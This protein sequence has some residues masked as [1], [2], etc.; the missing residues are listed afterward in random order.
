VCD[1]LCLCHFLQVKGFSKSHPARRIVDHEDCFFIIGRSWTCTANKGC[2]E[3]RGTAFDVRCKLPLAAQ[4]AFPAV[5]THRSGMSISVLQRLRASITGRVSLRPF[6]QALR[7]MHSRCFDIAKLRYL[8][9]STRLRDHMAGFMNPKPIP[10]DF[11]DVLMVFIRIPLPF[12]FLLFPF[13]SNHFNLIF[14]F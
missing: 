3:F 5:L 1:V 11:S 14:A 4:Y 13:L 8:S 9:A 2:S 6:F 12:N 7:T 10:E